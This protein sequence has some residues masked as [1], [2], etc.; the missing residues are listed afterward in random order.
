MSQ[1][2]TDLLTAPRIL[3]L[4]F[5]ELLEVR[6]KAVVRKVDFRKHL[7]ETVRYEGGKKA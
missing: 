1:I 3:L 7:K 6:M 4:D 2:P 5:L